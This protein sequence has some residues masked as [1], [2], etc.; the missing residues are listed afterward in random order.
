M[1]TPYRF[2]IHWI[3]R[4]S[5]SE[6]KLRVLR[7]LYANGLNSLVKGWFSAALSVSFV[8][9][10]FGWERGFAEWRVTI[11]GIQLHWQRHFGGWIT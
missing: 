10:L 1:K 5:Q 3:N 4:Y 8:E 11:L 6:K 2:G 9:K 7:V